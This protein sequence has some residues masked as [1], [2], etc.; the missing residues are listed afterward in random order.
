M[1]NVANLVLAAA[2]DYQL[3]IEVD[4]EQGMVATEGQV[5]NYHLVPILQKA[6]TTTTT[7][8]LAFATKVAASLTD[9]AAV[10]M[11]AT[12]I[13]ER[14]VQESYFPSTDTVEANFEAANDT[15]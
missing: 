10:K 1:E 8:T 9:V 4:I 14:S 2:I 13:A 7:T 6:T 15:Y 11:Q 5:E 3:K 12:A